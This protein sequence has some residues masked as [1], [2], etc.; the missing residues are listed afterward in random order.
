L[1][2]EMG[3]ILAAASLSFTFLSLLFKAYLVFF[4]EIVLK[5]YSLKSAILLAI[6][7]A[8]AQLG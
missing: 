4:T 5:G 7:T 6:P 2:A 1:D 8:L 3:G